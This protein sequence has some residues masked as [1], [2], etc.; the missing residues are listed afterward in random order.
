MS[1]TDLRYGLYVA[2]FAADFSRE[3]DFKLCPGPVAARACGAGIEHENA[4]NLLK[5]RLV[6]VAEHGQLT[7]IAFSRIQ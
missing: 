1:E 5:A 7:L 3:A 2:D 4:L 6:G